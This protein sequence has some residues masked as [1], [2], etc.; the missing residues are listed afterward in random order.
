MRLQTTRRFERGLRRAIRRRKDPE[1][2]W[3]IVE[4]LLANQ[5]LE[6]H[7]RLHRLIG[8]WSGCWECH[9]EPDW[10]LVWEYEE[11]LLILRET[12]THSDIFG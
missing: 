3:G 5:P 4:N 7:N 12:G 1:K 8:N 2:L 6:P 10:L 9:I 11:D